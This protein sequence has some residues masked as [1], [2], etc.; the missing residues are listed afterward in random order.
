M[1]NA[2]EEEGNDEGEPQAGEAE[3]VGMQTGQ[4]ADGRIKMEG[5]GQRKA[6]CIHFFFS[7]WY[8]RL[9]LFLSVLFLVSY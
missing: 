1:L 8:P 3:G 9:P 6:D 7:S 4:E 2:G 5:T